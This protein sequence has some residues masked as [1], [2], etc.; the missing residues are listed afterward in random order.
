MTAR[1]DGA[2]AP[3]VDA[4]LLLEGTYP[5]MRGGVS[6]WVHR[7]VEAM[8]ETTFSAV[9]LGGRRSDHGAPAYPAPPNLRHL[10]CHYLFDG[11]AG[12]A[13]AASGPPSPF[14]DIDRLHDLL[15]SDGPRRP[16]E[17]GL[18]RRLSRALVEGAGA[19]RD[20]FLLGEG[21]WQR[22]CHAYRRDCP[23]GSFTDWFWT[24]RAMHAALF[25]L[26]DIA[27]RLPPARFYHAVSTGYAGLLGTLLHHHT[28]RPLVLSEHG[29]YTKERAIDLAGAE[30]MPGDGEGRG[31]GF[32]RR[33]WIRLF[34]GL[35]RMTYASADPIIALYEGNRQRQI[36][37]GA[38]PA[39]TR[40]VPNGV[41]LERFRALRARRPTAPPPVLGFLGRVVPIKDVKTFIRATKVVAAR[42]PQ[43][44]ALVV[45]PTDEDRGYAA[46]C[47]QLASSLGLGGRM[48]FTGFRP[49]EEI[50]PR[51]GLLV[52]TSISEALP[53]VVLEAFASGLP[54]V[55][56]DVGAC[57]QL[58]EGGT[59][60]DRALGAA[61]AVVPMGNPEAI[62]RAA[63]ALLGDPERWRAAQ[64]AAV[65]R[66]EKSYGF[67]RMI[68][69]YRGIYREASAWRA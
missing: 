62:A 9:F 39:R 12:A 25:D 32:G 57:R 53:L 61:G 4:A 47:A 44:E 49:P 37:D 19:A 67:D 3:P 35:G 55:A 63:L 29:I 18:V 51:L 23:E 2:G 6:A 41:D 22:I 8:P 30:R 68:D 34:E 46:E 17:A 33:L 26:A 28:G 38:D 58:I 40:V 24:V 54:V 21:S 60:E 16:L 45:G 5:F 69:A 13:A 48:E 31:L 1:R 43:A 64:A 11:E 20:D 14:D 56:T 7:L 66:V 36:R 42:L 15:R 52:I 59:A 65:R 27:R 50:L 10:E